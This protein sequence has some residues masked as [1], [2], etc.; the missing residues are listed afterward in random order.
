VQQGE[1]RLTLI[2]FPIKELTETT[3]SPIVIIDVLEMVQFCLQNL[4][5]GG[6][7]R[8]SSLQ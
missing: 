6:K 7:V 1:T 5:E 8:Q 4:V 2:A 3:R